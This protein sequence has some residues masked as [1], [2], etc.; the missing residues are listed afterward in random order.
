MHS[1]LD[2]AGP[3]RHRP[4][5]PEDKSASAFDSEPRDECSPRKSQAEMMAADPSRVRPAKTHL[6]KDRLAPAPQALAC[7]MRSKPG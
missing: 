4:T 3:L 7:M 2:Q 6:S 5:D 1:G